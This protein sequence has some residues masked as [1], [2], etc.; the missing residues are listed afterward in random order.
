MPLNEFI[1]NSMNVFNYPVL[2]E[3]DIKKFLPSTEELFN[4][5]STSLEQ[6]KRVNKITKNDLELELWL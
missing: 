4:Q 5:C 2:N 1:V 6:I 3:E